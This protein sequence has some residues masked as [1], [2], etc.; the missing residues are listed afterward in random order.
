MKTITL[1]LSFFVS[2]S[3][4]CQTYPFAVHPDCDKSLESAA[5]KQ[6]S[7]DKIIAAIHDRIRYTHY[8][9]DQFSIVELEFDINDKG[10]IEPIRTTILR[11]VDV[12]INI[13]NTLKSL[14]YQLVLK[15][16]EDEGFTFYD[17]KKLVIKFTEAN[18]EELTEVEA[19]AAKEEEVILPEN[20]ALAKKYIATLT[21]TSSDNIFKKGEIEEMIMPRFFSP[22]CEE[23]EGNHET[24]QECAKRKM[25]EFIYGNIKYPAI[26]RESGVEGTVVVQFI[27]EQDGSMGDI[28]VVR[29]IGAKC[30]VESLRVIH[31]MNDF[32]LWIPGII[33]EKTVRVQF[34]LPVNFRLE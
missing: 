9:N 26:A 10:Y 13:E 18:F 2:T 4:F 15:P 12:K 30:G 6:C 25:L 29:D 8:E 24:K 1:L 27:V 3:L 28:K 20:Q 33:E 16:A 32:T 23:L 19:E 31:A 5:L 34:Y 11:G 17:N 7:E 14:S 22:E 21:P